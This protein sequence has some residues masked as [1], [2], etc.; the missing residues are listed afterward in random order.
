MKQATPVHLHRILFQVNLL[1]EGLDNPSSMQLYSTP[2]FCQVQTLIPS[3]EHGV[4]VTWQLSKVTPSVYQSPLL[5]SKLC[6][7][8]QG[9]S[10][11]AFPSHTPVGAYSNFCEFWNT[12]PRRRSLCRHEQ[13]GGP[14]MESVLSALL[15]K[16]NPKNHEQNS[17][18]WPSGIPLQYA[19][20]FNIQNQQLMKPVSLTD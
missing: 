8:L 19:G 20:W 4:E 12:L 17:I 5:L 9:R 10:E 18:P 1:M 2:T 14:K 15:Y 11:K 3:G 16:F 7:P 6:L 13:D